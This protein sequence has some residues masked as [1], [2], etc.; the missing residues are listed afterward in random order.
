M[1]KILVKFRF[2]Q[3]PGISKRGTLKSLQSSRHLDHSSKDSVRTKSKAKIKKNTEPTPIPI[4][5]TARTREPW[6]QWWKLPVRSSWVLTDKD[7][8]GCLTAADYRWPPSGCSDDYVLQQDK[9]WRT[10]PRREAQCFMSF[11]RSKLQKVTVNWNCVTF[12]IAVAS[13]TPSAWQKSWQ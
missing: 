4:A 7:G 9:I 5:F 6:K 3:Y 1:F 13:G 12:T 10:L 2:F 8:D 11:R